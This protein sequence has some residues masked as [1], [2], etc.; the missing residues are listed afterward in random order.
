MC[1]LIDYKY[2]YWADDGN[3]LEA[4]VI[5]EI[6]FYAVGCGGEKSAR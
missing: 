4:D 2:V 6:I 5:G 1:R 3:I